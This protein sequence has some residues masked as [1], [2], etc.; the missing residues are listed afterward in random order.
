MFIEHHGLYFFVIIIYR[1][2]TFKKCK[3][4]LQAIVNGVSDLLVF[5]PLL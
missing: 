5:V 1:V 2:N 3:S 4:L